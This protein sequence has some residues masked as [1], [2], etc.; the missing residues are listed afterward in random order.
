MKLSKFQ[1]I[2]FGLFFIFII[3]GVVAFATYKSSSSSKSLPAIT[4]WG[5]FP[6]DKFD[7]YVAKT[8]QSLTM[9]ISVQYVEKN[10]DNFTRELV[11]ALARGTGPDAILISAE[12]LYPNL[13]KIVAIPYSVLNVRTFKDSYVEAGE[14]YMRNNGIVGIPFTIDPLVMYWNR[15][16]FA[17]AGLASYPRYWE[18]FGYIISKLTVKDNAGNIKKTAI[19]LGDFTNVSNAR[20]I[21]GSILF[22]I[23]NPITAFGNNPDVLETTIRYSIQPPNPQ[24]VSD[25]FVQFINPNNPYYSWNRGMIND[26]SAFL[27]GY[28]STYFGF[29][30]EIKDI[31][32]KN[33]NLNFDVAPFPQLKNSVKK[34]TYGK[35]YGFSILKASPVQNAAFQIVS[36]LTSPDVIKDM[37]DSLYLPSVR[38]DIIAVGSNDPYI[39]IFNSQALIAH[40]WLDSSPEDS[41]RLMSD[42]ISSITSGAKKTTEAI[43]DFEGSYDIILQNAVQ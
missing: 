1:L 15:D 38:R 20:E 8:N 41:R 21:F 37:S 36:I 25:F 2:F 14:L 42:M 24:T 26:K 30:S 4:I 12:N 27:A 7:Q 33:P 40:T 29:A 31:A 39:S 28:L 6:K 10:A 34:A 13:D 18:D 16:T 11:Q 35:M 19:A 22:Q 5:T 23:G 3:M 9:P 43:K 32:N 17:S